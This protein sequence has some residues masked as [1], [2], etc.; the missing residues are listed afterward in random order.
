MHLASVHRLKRDV[1]IDFEPGHPDVA[2]LLNI[3]FPCGGHD[4][5]LVD[6]LPLQR[7]QLW[8]ALF[9]QGCAPAQNNASQTRIAMHQCRNAVVEY[10][11]S[12]GGNDTTHDRRIRSGHCVLDCIGEQENAMTG[13]NTSVMGG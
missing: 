3:M 5:I 10:E 8:Y 11:E 1:A 6:V 7:V 13:P 2:H 9:D 12:C 4:F